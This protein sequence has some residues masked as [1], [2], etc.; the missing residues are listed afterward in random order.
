MIKLPSNIKR[1][2]LFGIC[3]IV[4]SVLIVYFPIL[5]GSFKTVYDS[6]HILGNALLRDPSNI[7]QILTRNL[8]NADAPYRPFTVLS[9]MAEV[10]VF[11]TIPYF[12]YLGNIILHAGAALLVFAIMVMI[13]K[14][15][16]LGFLTALVFALHPAHWEAVSFLSGRAVLLNTFFYLAG[17][18]ACVRYMRR[19]NGWWLTLSL[20]SFVCALFSHESFFS[21]VLV[22]FT[23]VIFMLPEQPLSVR[24][25]AFLP[26]G[27][28]GVM[29]SLIRHG[30]QAFRM[31]F[32]ADILIVGQQ[33]LSALKVM[34]IQLGIVAAPFKVH[35]H[36]TSDA[37][38]GLNDIKVI[39]ALA[40]LFFLGVVL[41]LIR[42][43][44]DMLFIFF[45]VWMVSGLWPLLTSGFW[46]GGRNVAVPVDG[47]MS[48]MASIALIALVLIA[49]QRALLLLPKGRWIALIILLYVVT[50]FGIL[51]FK[52]N[53]LAVD[54]MAVLNEAR[55][56]K[57][58]SAIFEYQSGL[59]SAS[60]NA[61]AKAQE[62][63]ERALSLDANFT[64]ASMGQGKALYDQGKLEEAAKVYESINNPGRY[65]DVLSGN[66]R[67][68][69]SQLAEKYE[70]VVVKEPQNIYAQFS[71]GIY[72]D[73]LGEANRSIAAFQQVV[74]L[75]P[76]GTTGLTPIALRFQGL[77][78][79]RLGERVKAQDNFVRAQA[80]SSKV[81]P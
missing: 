53:V 36:Q 13:T 51:T 75:D 56:Y 73:K 17:L 3:V 62:H 80:M 20:V 76:K 23:Y 43:K 5:D 28:V 45:M 14:D 61:H 6:D 74:E 78:F 57:P 15:R 59:V 44:K 9:H 4:L 55:R 81:R 12:S 33:F 72:Y 32:P 67:V 79:D 10:R 26:Y 54:E 40:S 31:D 49:S 16:M 38:Q 48:Y 60:R 18:A 19:L 29:F 47:T 24:W 11:G 34:F 77:I 64:S 42:K 46:A 58:A 8:F 2:Y 50:G 70:A 66:L 52:H 35:F 25:L 65:R 22:F 21:V 69:Y 27:V 7:P 63:F 37:W 30:S 41:A 1:S 68:I 39:I 71:L